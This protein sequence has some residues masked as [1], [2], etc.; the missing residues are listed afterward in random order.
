MMAS[1]YSRIEMYYN[2]FTNC[3]SK[4][5]VIITFVHR[6]LSKLPI[7]SPDQLL[8]NGFPGLKSKNI[9]RFLV[10]IKFTQSNDIY[11][12]PTW[13]ETKQAPLCKLPPT[14]VPQQWKHDLSPSVRQHA[15]QVLIKKS[16]RVETEQRNQLSSK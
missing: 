15:Q 8:Q 11:G 7:I 6:S 16:R 13:V 2:L 12:V 3:P 5:N 9:L 4:N 14:P 1:K 10:S